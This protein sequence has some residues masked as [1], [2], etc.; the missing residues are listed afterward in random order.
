VTFRRCFESGF[1]WLAIMWA[2]AVPIA[3]LGAFVDRHGKTFSY[4]I[5][6]Y[7][8]DFSKLSPGTVMVG[9]SVRHAIEEGFQVYDFLRGDESY[10][11]SFGAVERANANCMI[12]RRSLRLALRELIGLLRGFLLA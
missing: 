11:F 10:K 9:H 6:G 5:G 12:T 4:W 2:G 8:D 1:L 3:G 7:N